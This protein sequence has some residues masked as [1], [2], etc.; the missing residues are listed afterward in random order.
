ML[1]NFYIMKNSTL[2]RGALAGSKDVD[3]ADFII[4][5]E[6][7]KIFIYNKEYNCTY[8]IIIYLNNL[9]VMSLVNRVNDLEGIYE[10]DI[11]R[12]KR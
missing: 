4:D 11:N 6:D 9:Y 3:K 10:K 5:L 8:R 7:Q 12:D 1:F 2:L